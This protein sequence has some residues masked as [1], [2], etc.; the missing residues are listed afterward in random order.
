M[1]TVQIG[2][3]V[4][5]TGE[6]PRTIQHWSD[7]GILRPEKDTDKQGRGN[8]RIYRSEPLHGERTWALLASAF[9]KLRLPLGDIRSLINSLRLMYDPMEL[10]DKN[11]PHF[12]DALQIRSDREKC[13]G[14][15]DPFEAA[16]AGEQEVLAIIAKLQHTEVPFRIVYLKQDDGAL[17]DGSLV[18]N[19]NLMRSVMAENKSAVVLNLSKIFE[20]LRVESA[21]PDQDSEQQVDANQDD[22]KLECVAQSAVA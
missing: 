14:V 8:Y 18:T 22:Q 17:R 2:V 13:P 20:P 5:D 3:L 15:N 21:L 16:I 10:I 6:K 1:E 12:G 4:Q 7:L 9:F 19:N 11:D